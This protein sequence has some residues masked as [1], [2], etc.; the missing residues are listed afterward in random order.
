MPNQAV[1][2]RPLC[3]PSFCTARSESHPDNVGDKWRRTP[4]ARS[5]NCDSADFNQIDK[6]PGEEYV[7][8]VDQAEM[9][10][11]ERPDGRIEKN[12]APWHATSA[13]DLLPHR[14][15]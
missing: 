6:K 15:P 4:E 1:A 12:F 13:R 7:K 10:D 9:G 14:S 8:R 2:R 5:R 11:H 3:F